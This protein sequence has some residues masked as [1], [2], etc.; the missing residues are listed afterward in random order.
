MI[1]LM[2]DTGQHVI[3]FFLRV[4][5]EKHFSKGETLV[6][7]HAKPS[8]VFLLTKGVVKA[9]SI[10]KT[11]TSHVHT[12]FGIGK[13]FPLMRA[14]NGATNHI[15]C[16]AQEGVVVRSISL[17]RFLQETEQNP[18]FTLDLLHQTVSQFALFTNRIEN[19]EYSSAKERLIYR[20]LSLA[21]TLGK[22]RADTVVLDLAI[23]HDDL[24]ASI[25]VS[26]EV[27]SRLMRILQRKGLVQY[28][29]KHIGLQ[30]AQL[31]AELHDQA[32]DLAVF[33][34]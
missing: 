4:G 22:Q 10:D 30:P 33:G 2:Q 34:L 31:L 12:F 9:F 11:G 26:R 32:L 18:N 25:Q 5:K 6:H 19:L 29:R 15:M 1:K 14:L 8:E 27:V 17:E 16:V 24:A 23:T 20:L 28:S 21:G 13:C 7:A 3:D